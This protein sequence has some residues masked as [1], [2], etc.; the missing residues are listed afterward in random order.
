MLVFR[1]TFVYLIS[2]NQLHELV[3][4]LLDRYTERRVTM[5][6]A[7]CAAPCCG[8]LI[9]CVVLV[10]DIAKM[11]SLFAFIFEIIWFMVAVAS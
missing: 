4:K 6:L 10:F 11:A 8:S 7:G 1:N 3:V 5:L 2:G 9:S